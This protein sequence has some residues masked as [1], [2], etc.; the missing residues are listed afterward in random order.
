VIFSPLPV[1]GLVEQFGDVEAV[2]HRPGLGQQA[3]TGGVVRRPHVGPVGPDLPP[4]LLGQL[5]QT[6]PAGRLVAPLG[7]GQHFGP[8]RVGQIGQDG[9][10]QFVPL[11]EAQFIDAHVRDDPPGIDPAGPGVGQLVPDDQPDRLRRHAEPTG[12]LLLGAADQRP[13]DVLLEA[14]GIADLPPLEGRDEVLTVTAVGAAVE[15]GLIDPEAG[16]APE[17]Q[18]PD[19]L[20]T[21]LALDAG[22]VLAAA[23]VA[24]AAL[25][26]RPSDL[27]AVAV[28]VAV[29]GGDGDAGRQIDINGDGGHDHP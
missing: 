21:A 10:E 24:A 4:L 9:H 19:H 23:A 3:A 14:A 8:L 6:L 26:P 20:G 15:G 7:H 29:V 11:L 18:I 1:H 5:L 13:Q 25:R 16:L 22:V 2:D 17:V 12:D 28:A 27:E